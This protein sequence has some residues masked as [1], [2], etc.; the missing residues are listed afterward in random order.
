[1]DLITHIMK[2]HEW[3]RVVRF[4]P[5]RILSSFT[6]TPLAMCCIY[7]STFV[8]QTIRDGR[9]YMVTFLVYWAA[10]G[11]K[12]LEMSS[13]MRSKNS[14][15]R[16]SFRAR[17]SSRGFVETASDYLESST[18]TQPRGTRW[19][20][21]HSW[22]GTFGYGSA[23]PVPEFCCQACLLYKLSVMFLDSFKCSLRAKTVV[24]EGT[25]NITNHIRMKV[26]W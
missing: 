8:H 6:S 18:R 9:L 17:Q 14:I 23:F 16:R 13:L 4:K 26:V 22:I 24:R 11:T 2:V 20:H 7:L 10:P 25:E 3:P 12:W 15:L 1:M 5:R 21:F 19:P